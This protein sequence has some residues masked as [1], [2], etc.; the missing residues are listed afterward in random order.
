[1]GERR[2]IPVQR[3]TP[4]SLTIGKKGFID[5]G[6]RLQEETA[7]SALTVILMLVGVGL[8]RVIFV[9]LGTTSLQFHGWLVPIS[10]RPLL[11]IAAVF[12]MV[13]VWSSCS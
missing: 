12:V 6:R 2:Q 13:I 1:M 9:I 11:G 5:R 7:Q 10:L 8:T 3:P 4:P